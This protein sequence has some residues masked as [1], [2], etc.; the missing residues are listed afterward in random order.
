MQSTKNMLV[1]GGFSSWRGTPIKKLLCTWEVFGRIYTKATNDLNICMLLGMLKRPK[2]SF[3]YS[4]KQAQTCFLTCYKCWSPDLKKE[5]C[6]R[7]WGKIERE[8]Y[9]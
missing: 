4:F 5:D 7:I 3:L 6:T 2:E 9:I 1:S 8:M